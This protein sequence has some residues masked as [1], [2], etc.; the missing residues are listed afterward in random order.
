[1]QSDFQVAWTSKRIASIS[2]CVL[3]TCRSFFHHLLNYFSE[4]LP[5][6]LWLFFFPFF[7]L[8]FIWILTECFFKKIIRYANSLENNLSLDNN[9]TCSYSA[10]TQSIKVIGE[11]AFS[12]VEFMA[13]SN[14]SLSEMFS[15]WAQL[16]RKGQKRGITV[17]KDLEIKRQNTATSLCRC[18]TALFLVCLAYASKSLS[19]IQ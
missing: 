17:V 14:P 15:Q 8:F 5:R 6:Y 12:S 19:G 13:L 7:F 18:F 2:W 16:P 9:I 3:F 11:R 1:M 4:V 10:S